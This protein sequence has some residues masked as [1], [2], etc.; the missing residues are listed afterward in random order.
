MHMMKKKSPTLYMVLSLF[1]FKVAQPG[2]DLLHELHPARPPHTD[3]F[4]SGGLQPAAGVE[5]SSQLSD[6]KVQHLHTHSNRS[7]FGFSADFAVQRE[8]T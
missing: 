4:H 7:L 2:T 1:V 3:S 8:A 5:F 6:P